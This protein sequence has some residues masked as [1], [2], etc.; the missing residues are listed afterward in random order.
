MPEVIA[1]NSQGKPTL[2]EVQKIIAEFDEYHPPQDLS[3]AVEAIGIPTE[4]K[5]ISQWS[6]RVQKLLVTLSDPD[7]YGV[8]EHLRDLTTE[9]VYAHVLFDQPLEPAM[10][11]LTAAK[12][13]AA[14]SATRKTEAPIDW[15]FLIRTARVQ[16]LLSRQDSDYLQMRNPREYAVARAARRLA[17]RGF[18][19][20]QERIQLSLSNESSTRLIERLEELIGELGGLNVLRELFRRAADKYDVSSE[21]YM[22]VRDLGVRQIYAPDFPWG[23]LIALSAK[24]IFSR[25]NRRPTHEAW[26]DL[27]DLATDYS[28]LHDVQDYS[29]PI[30]SQ[31]PTDKLVATLTKRAL[32]DSIHTFPQLRS[33]DVLRMLRPLLAQIPPDRAYGTGWTINDVF[34]VIEQLYRAIGDCRGPV[35]IDLR[36]VSKSVPGVAYSLAK[37]ILIEVL[38]H[39]LTGPNSQF[40]RPTDQAVRGTDPL[41]GPGN[42]LYLRP[43]IRSDSKRAIVI[44]RSVAGPAIVEAVL[45]AI[46]GYEGADEFQGNVIGAGVETLIRWE[47][48][49]HGIAIYTGDYDT[50]AGQGECDVVLDEPGNVLFI[51][52]KAKPLTRNAANGNDVDVLLSLAG[53]VVAATEQ[54]FGHEVRL[55]RYGELELYDKKANHTHILKWTDQDVDRIALSLYDFG[56]FQDQTAIS[57]LVWPMLGARYNAIDPTVQATFKG[58]FEKLN[59]KVLPRLE[60]HLKIWQELGVK[61]RDPFGFGSWFLSVPQLFALLDG[62][63]G[64]AEFF[65]RLG[66]LRNLTYQSYNFHHQLKYALDL[67]TARDARKTGPGQVHPI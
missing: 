27:V 2:S 48:E 16:S 45:S 54:S 50:P 52:S 49:Q 39:P 15:T 63:H 13:I 1:S 53:S 4:G 9:V 28:A 35:T 56:F 58:Q 37:H 43:L 60:G 55:R 12:S 30:F 18:P 41:V 21:R 44:D 14:P 24:H 38:S 61:E 3:A 64:P 36:H 42:S 65:A 6:D 57:K 22:I 5:G 32:Y 66:F 19:V 51:E 25:G 23:Y 7:Q 34:A 20:E 40:T 10:G 47:F 26:Q 62:V 33:S 46:R 59:E 11:A 29:P 31:I 17:D 8:R 67:K